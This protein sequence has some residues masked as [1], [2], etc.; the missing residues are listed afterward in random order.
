MSWPH[1]PARKSTAPTVRNTP[2]LFTKNVVRTFTSVCW[3][4]RAPSGDVTLSVSGNV[5]EL[6]VS[7]VKRTVVL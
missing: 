6:R 4:G 5:P 3:M 1:H 7:T 2:T